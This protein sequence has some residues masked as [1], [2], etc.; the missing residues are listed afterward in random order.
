VTDRKGSQWVETGKTWVENQ[1]N[2][3]ALGLGVVVE[4]IGWTQG[5]DGCS[6]GYWTLMVRA[7]DSAARDKFT[8]RDL[9]DHQTPKIA[10]ALRYQVRTVL[11]RC[12]T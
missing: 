4:E 8:V 5:P 12:R 2:A 10:M 9:E 7:V 11:L 6:Q 3:L 1:I